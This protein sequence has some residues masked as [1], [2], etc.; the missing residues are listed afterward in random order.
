MVERQQ[1]N[2]Q[3]AERIAL[4]YDWLSDQIKESKNSSGSCQACGNCCDFDSFDHRLFVT[5]PELIYLAE[6]IG[7]ENIKLMANGKCSYNLSGKCMIYENR[8]AGCRIFC[9]KGN[10]DFQSRLSE[11]AIRKFKLI[12]DDFAIDYKYS[13]LKTALNSI[14]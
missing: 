10:S 13:D 14:H 3:I 12:C 2:K 5:T 4:V 1:Q 8:F 7:S 11:S 6:K 9:C